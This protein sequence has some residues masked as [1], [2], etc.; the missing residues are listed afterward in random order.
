MERKIVHKH[1]LLWILDER[2][3]KIRFMSELTFRQNVR[4]SLW[5]S[6]PKAPVYCDCYREYSTLIV[7]SD[8]ILAQAKRRCTIIILRLG[9]PAACTVPCRRHHSYCCSTPNIYHNL[10]SARTLWSQILISQID[11]LA[12][13]HQNQTDHE[14][15]HWWSQQ[16]I[17]QFQKTT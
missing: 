17:S 15:W 9:A 14:F 1:R 12:R 10:C 4:G 16:P 13:R 6:R 3:V 11:R 2:R 7:L 5:W 8:R